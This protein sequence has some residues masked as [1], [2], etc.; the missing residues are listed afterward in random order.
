MKQVIRQL[1]TV[2]IQIEDPHFIR[3]C[4]TGQPPLDSWSDQMMPLNRNV[5]L[6]WTE[7]ETEGI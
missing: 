6:K 2:S 3:I 4:S 7:L 1:F 5:N